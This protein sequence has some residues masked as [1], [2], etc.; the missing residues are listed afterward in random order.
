MNELAEKAKLLYIAT[1]WLAGSGATKNNT[2]F[3]RRTLFPAPNSSQPLEEPHSQTKSG[4]CPTGFYVT[5]FYEPANAETESTNAWYHIWAV[6]RK[7]SLLFV[8]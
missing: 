5:R 2:P 1:N 3:Y 4:V 7:K 6:Y 8:W